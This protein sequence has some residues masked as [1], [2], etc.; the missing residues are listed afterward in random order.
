MS[1]DAQGADSDPEI[2][3]FCGFRIEDEGRDVG[4]SW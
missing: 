3:E 4:T 2:C 1:S